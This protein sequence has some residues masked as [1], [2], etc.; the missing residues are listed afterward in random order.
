MLIAIFAGIL[1]QLS[2]VPAP[3]EPAPSHPAAGEK[4]CRRVTLPNWNKPRLI[5]LTRAQWR[6][7]AQGVTPEQQEAMLGRR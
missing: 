7:V 3:P 1:A 2:F 4:V 6:E 5:C